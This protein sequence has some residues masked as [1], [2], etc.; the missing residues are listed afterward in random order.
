MIYSDSLCVLHIP[1]TGGIS[2]HN[3]VAANVPGCREVRAPTPHIPLRDIERYTGHKPGLFRKIVAVVRDPYDQ[4]LSQWVHYRDGYAR[5]G[6]SIS[7]VV[8]ALYPELGHWLI[9]PYAD[10]H[11]AHEE[12]HN[13]LAA[14]EAHRLVQG[15][16]YYEYYLALDGE[17]PDNLVVVPFEEYPVRF[18]D[19]VRE[20]VPAEPT[21]FPH[22][23]KS[24]PRNTV[25]YYSQLATAIVSHKFRWSIGRGMVEGREWGEWREVV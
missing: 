16:G 11:M 4:Q 19:A 10:A 18:I 25:A 13:G 21:P 3:W 14:E 8:A 1:K 24:A 6:R 20:L 23:N 12:Y 2:A 7:E 5:G 17:T 9:D 15:L 22:V